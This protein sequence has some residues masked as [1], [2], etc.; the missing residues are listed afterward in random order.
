MLLE[1]G[2]GVNAQN[3]QGETHLLAAARKGGQ[4]AVQALLKAKADP[5]LT[6]YT[7][8]TALDWARDGRSPAYAPRPTRCAPRWP[9]VQAPRPPPRST[10]SRWA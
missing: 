6:D 10:A 9:S 3:R 7:G 2:S 1:A 5:K 8:K 4:L